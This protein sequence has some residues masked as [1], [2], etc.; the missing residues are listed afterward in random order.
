L[1]FCHFICLFAIEGGAE[2]DFLEEEAEEELAQGRLVEVG[3]EACWSL[4]SAKPGFGVEQ[5]RDNNLDT[6]WQYAGP[7]SEPL[8]IPRCLLSPSMGDL[9][10]DLFLLPLGCRSDGPQPHTVSIQWHRRQCIEVRDLDMPSAMCL[11]MVVVT[12]PLTRTLWG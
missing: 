4:S 1:S 9:L 10:T 12:N 11:I 6:Y 2:L 3:R 5:L 8:L 7:A